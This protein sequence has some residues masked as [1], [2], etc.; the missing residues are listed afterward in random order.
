MA[1]KGCFLSSFILFLIFSIISG[2]STVVN[3]QQNDDRNLQEEQTSSLRILSTLPADIEYNGILDL[4]ELDGKDPS[5]LQ[6]TYYGGVMVSGGPGYSITAGSHI[7][8]LSYKFDS[9]EYSAGELALDSVVFA[10]S[11]LALNPTEF[12]GSKCIST[13]SFTAEA[14][15]QYIV[16]AIHDPEG[17]PITLAV[18]Q[19]EG[20]GHEEACQQSKSTT[21][22]VTS[23][24]PSP[25]IEGNELAN[26][27]C[28]VVE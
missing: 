20:E 8:K 26:A 1:K 14:G 10:L 17:L 12:P 21:G 22:E 16:K 28:N 27:P 19:Y 25:D 23:C 9:P 4:I 7:L 18:V 24:L 13:V 3:V 11:L 15:H 2:C 5:N 6:S